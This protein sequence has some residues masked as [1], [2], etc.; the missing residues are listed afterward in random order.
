VNPLKRQFLYT[1]L[2][3]PLTF[4]LWY[5][6]GALFAG[7][8][9][10]LLDQCFAIWLTPW[11]DGTAIDG[12]LMVVT[13]GWGQTN[14]E[15]VPA[16]QAGNQL[17]FEVNT[18]LV[19]YGIAFYAALLGASADDRGFIHFGI[20][21]GL[22]WVVMAIGLAAMV[23]KDLMLNIGAPFLT[24]PAAPPATLIALVYQFSVLLAPTLIPV[25]IWA[26]QLRGSP[27]WDEL[28]AGVRAAAGR[29]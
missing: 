8:A 22:L 13:T 17:I 16:A 28:A 29:D 10:W 26:F 27:L 7:P 3:L 23:M 4:G 1:L 9:V 11:V 2:L 20:G 6:A 18:R 24:L 19:S 14:G 12:T 15:I 21:L 5:A 25:A